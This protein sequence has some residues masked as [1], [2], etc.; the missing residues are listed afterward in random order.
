[1]ETN[2]EKNS[3][4]FLQTN[5]ASLPDVRNKANKVLLV[6]GCRLQV[7]GLLIQLPAEQH[8]TFTAIQPATGIL[9]P[10]TLV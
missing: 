10:A 5:W 2:Y 8:H 6:T 7:A 1:M 4:T 9:Y 3:R